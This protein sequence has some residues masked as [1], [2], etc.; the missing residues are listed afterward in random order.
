MIVFSSTYIGIC[1]VNKIK[2][3]IELCNVIIDF[4]EDTICKVRMYHTPMTNIV[5]DNPKYKNIISQKY[6]SK[7]ETKVIEDYFSAF[8]K[9]DIDNEIRGLET[10]KI[11]FEKS[12]NSYEM[13]LSKKSKVY[14]SLGA[15]VGIIVSIILV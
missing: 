9:C 2:K 10:L 12:K 11:K 6:L 4:C 14:L 15:G 1:F 5:D 8:G 3:Q 13:E 7:E